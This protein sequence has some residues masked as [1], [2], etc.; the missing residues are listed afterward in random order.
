MARKL[1]IILSIFVLFVLNEKRKKEI[2]ILEKHITIAEIKIKNLENQLKNR[3]TPKQSP[4]SKLTFIPTLI[5]AYELTSK[6]T[7]NTPTINAINKKAKIGEFAVSRKIEKDGVL[8]LGDKIYFVH[9]GII[10]QNYVHDRMG[11]PREHMPRLKKYC[12]D[13]CVK[14]GEAKKFG[15]WQGFLVIKN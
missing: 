13:V 4:E 1:I 3:N 12:I 10:T 15:V 5:T 7:D 8:K 2:A 11:K 6:Q 9:N 14:E